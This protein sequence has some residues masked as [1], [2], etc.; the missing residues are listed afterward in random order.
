MIKLA[1]FSVKEYLISEYLYKHHMKKI[2]YFALNKQT[3]HSTIS[4]ICLAYLL[5]FNTP[6]PLD[7]NL[8]ES[9]PLAEYAAEHWIFHAKSTDYDESE[10][11]SFFKLMKKLLV[12]NNFAFY[13]WIQ[14]YNI[15]AVDKTW[16]DQNQFYDAEPLYYASLAGLTKISCHL[17][18]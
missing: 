5:Q 18:E 10:S 1:H 6:E 15:D 3:A 17:L 2:A 4:K 11:S 7:K 12:S 16:I 9:S 8:T 13:R 14:I